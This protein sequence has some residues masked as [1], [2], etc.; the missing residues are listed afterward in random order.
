MTPRRDTTMTPSEHANQKTRKTIIGGQTLRGA[1]SSW[2]HLLS[3]GLGPNQVE[4]SR[5]PHSIIT[6]DVSKPK[7][8]TANSFNRSCSRQPPAKRQS[9]EVPTHRGQGLSP[10][11]S[12]FLSGPR[13]SAPPHLLRPLH[14]LQEPHQGPPRTRSQGPHSG[15]G[16]RP[17]SMYPKPGD[18]HRLHS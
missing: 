9:E 16:P 3:L 17:G 8:G 2:N 11:S 18:G 4:V 10:P 1:G 14:L 13:S 6:R 5:Q 7:T 12:C 15:P